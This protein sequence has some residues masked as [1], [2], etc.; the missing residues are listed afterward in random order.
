MK[1]GGRGESA[2]LRR[3]PGA[4][5]DRAPA[6]PSPRVSSAPRQSAARPLFAGAHGVAG[7]PFHP[8]EYAVGPPHA[9]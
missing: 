5:R 9:P 2:R 6:V 4:G 3:P 8:P 1:E 7:R